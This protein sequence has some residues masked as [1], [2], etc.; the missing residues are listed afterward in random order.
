MHLRTFLARDMKE[1]L[2]A[3]RGAMGEDAIIVTSET[4]K[5][6]TVLLRAGIE[7]ESAPAYSSEGTS[8]KELKTLPPGT[9]LQAPA[10]ETRYRENLLARLRGAGPFE[11]KSATTFDSMALTGILRSH[12]TPEILV[13]T[14]VEAAKTSGLSDMT[15]ALATALDK[16]MRI[17]PIDAG[18]RGAI[19][20]MGPPGAG[21]TVVAAR[22]A[23]QH[24]LAGAPV[25]LAATDLETA[26]QT[27]RLEGFADCLN[28]Q[29]MRIA[30][31]QMLADAVAQARETD[32]L[33]IAD[34]GGCDPREALP[35]E[36]MA[37]LSAGQ[38][39]LVGV[40]SA[41]GDAE[42]AG[43]IAASLVKL[44]A[45]RLIVTGLD[46]SRRLGSLVAIALSGAA[47]AHVTQSPYLAD[48]LETLTPMALARKLT[49]RTLPGVKEAA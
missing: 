20:L 22:L 44:G 12:R 30:T 46:L 24:C 7:Q 43:E 27:A 23:A 41:A 13:K 38:A 29:V 32:A 34:T 36:H 47:I 14:L 17:D 10:F 3:M 15:L 45:T 42:E 25:L 21:K 26:G 33:L 48:G 39:D 40:L 1:A 19:L 6:G 4:L 31:P 16:S 28:V 8:R 35:R 18:H 2:T 11:T 9:V 5:D 37:F 49:A